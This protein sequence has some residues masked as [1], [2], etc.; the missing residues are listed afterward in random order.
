MAHQ[1]FERRAIYAPIVLPQLMRVRF[2]QIKLIHDV[3]RHDAI[4]HRE[5]VGGGIVQ[6]VV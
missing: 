3:L 1:A 6:R 2:I 4:H 5:D